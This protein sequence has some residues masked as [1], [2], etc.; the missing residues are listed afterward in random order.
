MVKHPCGIC[1]KAVANTHKAIYCDICNKWIHISCNNLDRKTYIKLQRSNTIWYCISC[2]KEELPFNATTNQEFAKIYN[3]KHIIPFTQQKIQNFKVNAI[4][5]LKEQSN[6]IINCSNY[7][8]NEINQIND[9][10]KKKSFFSFLHM[11]ISSLPY[12]FEELEELLNEINIKFSV[13]G[14]SESKLRANLN[15][16]SNTTLKNYNIEHT[17]TESEKG[18]TLLHISSELN[19]KVRSDLKMYKTKELESVFIEIINKKGKN[20][21]IGCIYKHPKMLI[22]EFC[23]EFL[24]DLTEKLSRKIRKFT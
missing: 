5:L 3:G 8:I 7:D 21:I 13:I 1:Q 15:P 18:G 20:Q 16:L 23:E 6:N 2:M 11:N 14:I 10:D 9:V 17:T 19:Y 24:N 4:E 12:H 22:S